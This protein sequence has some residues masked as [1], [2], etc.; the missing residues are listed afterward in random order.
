M[1]RVKEISYQII[2]KRGSKW[3]FT[4]DTL[5]FQ[6]VTSI[7]VK[8]HRCCMSRRVVAVVLQSLLDDGV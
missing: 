8:L 5:I 4:F 1:P 6:H 7:P 3:E 2:N